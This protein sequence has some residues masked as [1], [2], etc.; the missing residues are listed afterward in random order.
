MTHVPR[1]VDARLVNET[2]PFLRLLAW[3]WHSEALYNRRKVA[4][5]QL[6]GNLVGIVRSSIFSNTPAQIVVL[7][8]VNEAQRY[9]YTCCDY[10]IWRWGE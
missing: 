1:E 5:P 6:L 4:I 3:L 7:K 10:L 8:L 2:V 9:R